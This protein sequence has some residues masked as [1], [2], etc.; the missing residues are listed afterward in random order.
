MR[1]S[2][3][4]DTCVW[5][6]AKPCVCVHARARMCALGARVLTCAPGV[7]G[8]RGWQPKPA[9]PAPATPG[10]N[11]CSSSSQAT[12]WT[13]MQVVKGRG[14][15]ATDG[16]L[17]PTPTA[18]RQV[19]LSPPGPC[20]A[21]LPLNRTSPGPG[22]PAKNPH[23]TRASRGSSLG[24]GPRRLLLPP[25]CPQAP[26]AFPDG[27]MSASVSP[28]RRDH[29]ATRCKDSLGTAEPQR[30][31]HVCR[32]ARVYANIHVGTCCALQCTP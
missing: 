4:R 16:T 3:L 24:S 20:Q 30:S 19:G 31:E 21:A 10:S 26:K 29:E 6:C 27:F 7:C 1:V 22:L 12:P 5:V 28:C 9:P 17:R 32:H 13:Q 11:P 18:P 25:Q 2:G 15:R 23:P 14:S 8:V